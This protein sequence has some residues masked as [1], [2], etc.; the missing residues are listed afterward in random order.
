MMIIIICT[1]DLCSYVKMKIGHA[2]KT[3]PGG[4]TLKNVVDASDVLVDPPACTFCGIDG[5]T[6]RVH[7]LL[8]FCFVVL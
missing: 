4:R 8:V 2:L 7:F 5:L 1:G 6:G 3:H